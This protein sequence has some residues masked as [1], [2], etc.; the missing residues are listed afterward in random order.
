MPNP[1]QTVLLSYLLAV[2]P[3][4]A[5]AQTC[6]SNTI[7][8]STRHLI[9]NNNNGTVTDNKTGLMWKQCIEGQ[10][11]FTCSG[12]AGEFNWEEALRHA[13][14]VN[15]GLAGNNVG[16]TDW[17]LP[18]IKE[19]DSIIEGQCVEPA[20]NA[21]AFPNTLSEWFWSASPF[22]SNTRSAWG[23]NFYYGHNGAARKY[24]DYRIRL[25]RSVQ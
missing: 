10:D 21:L 9:I 14:D 5:N 6:Q 16:Y 18:N 4:I 25:V 23:V 11:P 1:I 8:A 17:R 2:L 3:L 20:I 7:P 19:L 24:Y 22:A 12:N 15:N 13:D